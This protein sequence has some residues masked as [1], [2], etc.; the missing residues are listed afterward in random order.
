MDKFGGE[1]PA[2]FFLVFPYGKT[3]ESAAPHFS[4]VVLKPRKKAVR[5]CQGEY[6]E[7]NRASAPTN[8]VV[9]CAV[10]HKGFRRPGMKRALR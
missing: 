4:A 2:L 6:E 7:N 8:S 3:A 9:F 5:P 1:T 10:Q